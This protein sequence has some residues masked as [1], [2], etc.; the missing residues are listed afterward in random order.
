MSSY[1]LNPGSMHGTAGPRL[2]LIND[3]PDGWSVTEY[4][5]ARRPDGSFTLTGLPAGDYHVYHHLIGEDRT[6]TSN[7]RQSTYRSAAAAWGGVG[8]HLDPA[9]PAAIAD[10]AADTLGDLPVRVVDGSGQPV[11][12][13]TLRVRDRMSDSWRQIEEDPGR[14]ESQGD[15]I[16]YPAAERIV[17]GQATLHKIRSG[18]LEFAVELDSGAA[19]TYRLPVTRGQLLNVTVPVGGVQ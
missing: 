8:V 3:N 15:P 7:G 10:F 2:Q 11:D 12:R 16:P 14:I 5:P 4:M 13:A 6:Y 18:W 19:Y 1:Q 17:T 9:R